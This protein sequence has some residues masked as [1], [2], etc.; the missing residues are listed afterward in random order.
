LSATL[1]DPLYLAAKAAASALVAVLVVDLLGVEDRLSA[2]FVAVVCTAPSVW[3]GVRR[4]LHQLAAS[5]LGGGVAVLLGLLLPVPITLVLATFATVWLCFRTGLGQ[6][7]IV[8]AFTVFYVLL[9]PGEHL[10]FTLEHRLASVVIGALAALGSNLVVSLLRLGAVLRR[11]MQIARAAL[12]TEWELAV[13]FLEAPAPVR[14]ARLTPFDAAF[15]LLRVLQEELTD[16]QRE[17]RLRTRRFREEVGGALEAARL[18]VAVAH[19]GKALVLAAQRQGPLP[20]AAKAAGELARAI[21][22]HRAVGELL[23]V[24]PAAASALAAAREAWL[25]CLSRATR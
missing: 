2:P 15:P 14:S 16:A 1:A 19:H 20:E 17:G 22:E 18:M 8:G 21:R 25:A 12:A 6:A 13:G 10:G 11:R 7:Y 23:S 24:E 5:V 4:G 3:G 9:I